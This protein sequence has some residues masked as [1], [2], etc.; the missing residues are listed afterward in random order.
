MKNELEE[1]SIKE[2]VLSQINQKK[3]LIIILAFVIYLIILAFVFVP[4]QGG[5]ISS[6]LVM[7][8]VDNLPGQY[9]SNL[10]LQELG[11]YGVSI[12]IAFVMQISI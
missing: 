8:P 10:P 4:L 5:L 2:K 9:E 6:T 11:Q 12:A 1:P 3:L 7:P